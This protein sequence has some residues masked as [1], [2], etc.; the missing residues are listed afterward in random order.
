MEAMEI[1]RSRHYGQRSGL[2]DSRGS[3]KVV[4]GKGAS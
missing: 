3:V 4:E 2:Q 1:L